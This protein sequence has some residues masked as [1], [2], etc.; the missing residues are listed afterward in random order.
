MEYIWFD[1]Q[2]ET[3]V[4]NALDA[5]VTIGDIPTG[6]TITIK[7]PVYDTEYQ[8][9]E[10]K[11]GVSV[12]FKSVPTLEQ[13]ATLDRFFIDKKREGGKAIHD[14]I[15]DLKAQVA[16]NTTKIDTQ[17][18]AVEALEVLATGIIEEPIE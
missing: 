15:D 7:H 12:R 1:K 17:E 18:L 5:D 16:A 11:R 4:L 14:E 9:P 10:T 13:L 3:E 6:K 8:I 2:N